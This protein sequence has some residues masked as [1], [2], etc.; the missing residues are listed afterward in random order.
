[1]FEVIGIAEYRDSVL[2]GLIFRMEGKKWYTSDNHV[3]CIIMR[4]R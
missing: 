1:M 2:M 3:I 4:G